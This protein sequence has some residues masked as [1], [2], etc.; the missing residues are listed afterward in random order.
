VLLNFTQ[1][2][3][4]ESDKRTDPEPEAKVEAID[5]KKR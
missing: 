1:R 4:K 3:G 2:K 5:P